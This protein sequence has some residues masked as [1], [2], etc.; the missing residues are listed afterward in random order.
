[1]SAHGSRVGS[2]NEDAVGTETASRSCRLPHCAGDARGRHLFDLWALPAVGSHGL[3]LAHLRRFGAQ[4]GDVVL[5]Q[6][7][8]DKAGMLTPNLT[9]TR[10]TP[11]TARR[12]PT[13][14]TFPIPHCTS[15]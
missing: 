13:F 14:D 4:D 7:L 15:K 9:T 3:H 8:K 6:T 1:M 2:W 12:H 5:Y 11:E 10:W